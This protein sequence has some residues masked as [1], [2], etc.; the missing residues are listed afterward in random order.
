MSLVVALALVFVGVGVVLGTALGVACS[1]NLH[2]YTDRT[3]VC[4]SMAWA[5]LEWWLVVLSPALVL[6]GSQAVPLCRRHLLLTAT[7]IALAA[8]LGWT[9]LLLGVSSNIG[10]TRSG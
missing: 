9:Y 10:D 3:A 2:P 6:L 1:E 7:A 4:E 5:G 8:G